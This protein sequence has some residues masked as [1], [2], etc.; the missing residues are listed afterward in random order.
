MMSDMDTD[1]NI[2]NEHPSVK[3]LNPL[4]KFNRTTITGN[5]IIN[6]NK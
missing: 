2:V 4:S 5:K 1:F 3:P 6:I